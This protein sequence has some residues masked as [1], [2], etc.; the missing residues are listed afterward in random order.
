MTFE[1][2]GATVYQIRPRHCHKAVPEVIPP[3]DAGVMI[4]DR[5]RSDDAQAFDGV[6]QQ[7]CLAH[8]LRSIHNVLERKTGQA[9]DFGEQLK[10][11]LQEALALWHEYQDGHVTG[12]KAEAEALQAELT[13]QL[14]YRRLKDPDH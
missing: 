9:R 13:Y 8:M 1:T 3:D 11:L 5:G 4:T 10:A 7:K 12:C 2:G 14:R 6:E